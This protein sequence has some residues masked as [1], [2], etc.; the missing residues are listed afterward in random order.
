MRWLGFLLLAAA[1]GGG[2]SHA[3]VVE[4]LPTVEQDVVFGVVRAD[5]DTA[6]DV[7]ISNPLDIDATAED[8]GGAGGRFAPEAGD[9]PADVAQGDTLTVRVVF[10]PDAPGTETGEIRV[11]FVGTT[12][13]CEVVLKLLAVV[14]APGLTL[15]TGRLAFPTIVV[16]EQESLDIR[17][18]NDTQF[19]PVSVTAIGSFPAD[20]THDFATRTLQPG[21]LMTIHVTFEPQAENNYDFTVA[22]ENSAGVTVR[23]RVTAVAEVR[24]AEEV[25]D[26]GTVS[27][28]NGQT[29]WFE[30]D[31]PDD[32]ISLSIEGVSS[33]T[34]TNAGLLGFEGPGG[35]IYENAQATGL[36]LWVPGEEGV[37]AATLPESDNPDVQLVPGGGTY[38]FRLYRFSGSGSTI[39][40]RAIIETRISGVA[41]EGRIDLNIFI[42]PGLSISSPSTDTKLQA[43][44]SRVDDIF[45][46]VNLQVGDVAYYQLGNSAYNSVSGSEF[47]AMLA[48]SS[49]ASETRM[50][51][52]LVQT[53]LGGGTLGVAAALPGPKLNGTRV[54]GVMV[55]YD[56]DNAAAVGQVTAHEVGHYLGLYHTAESDGV[57][58][59]IIED[60]LECP[61]ECSTASGGYL[62]HWQYFASSLPTITDGQAHVI[63]SHP[64]VDPIP[65]LSGLSALAQKNA[66]A[67]ALVYLPPNFCATCAKHK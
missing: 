10:T 3:I 25:V 55:D 31:L 23:V 41:D 66:P 21:D 24:V 7:V 48:E 30:V 62:M 46:Q 27:F 34:S 59:D 35:K 43:V 14:E 33:S 60:T 11:H 54:S 5:G 29:D 17:L 65:Q 67:L 8:M 32:A 51:I 20:F 61:D 9:L 42:A 50:N 47:P 28:T 13:E 38:R 39:H 49:A 58:H 36:F 44:L 63:L 52:F 40:V 64:L 2:G 12:Q 22:L 45:G 26:F 4:T 19:T 57:T 1:C 56:F 15:L 37:F 53:A 16:G 6:V 18:R